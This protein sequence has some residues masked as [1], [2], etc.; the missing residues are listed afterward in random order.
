MTVTQSLKINYVFRALIYI[1]GLVTMLNACSPSSTEI[2]DTS[3]NSLTETVSDKFATQAA[4]GAE[5]YAANCAA[6]HGLNLEGSTLGPILSGSSFLRRWSERTP[7]L[8]K[9]SVLHNT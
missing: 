4:S 6:C 8:A 1:L 9:D 2:S 5:A 3:N 7:A